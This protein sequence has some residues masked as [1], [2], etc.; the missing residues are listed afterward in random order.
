MFDPSSAPS[1][2]PTAGTPGRRAER[3]PVPRGLVW[4]T[5]GICVVALAGVGVIGWRRASSASTDT[6]QR[7][8]DMAHGTVVKTTVVST[9]SPARRLTL[10]GEARPFA[11]VTL[12]AK[13]SGYLK[14]IRVDRG[15]RVHKGDVLATI[16]SPETDRALS[17][18]RLEY[19]QR[20]VTADRVAHLLAKAFVSPQESDQAQAD[21]AVARERAAGFEEM[22]AY[23]TLRAPLDG[24][25]TARYAD[26][27]ALMQS[28]ATSQSSALPVLTV[29][30]T[31]RLRVFVYLDQEVAA[32][33]HPGTRAT[34]T[35]PDHPSVKISAA[36]TRL[37]GTLDAK[38]RKMVAE[39]DVDDRDGKVVP[40]SFI[41]V[42][43]E[44]PM[45]AL[46]EAP[47]EALL[48][49]GSSTYVGIID[50]TAHVHLTPVTVANNDGKLVT[51][52]SGVTAGQRVALSLGGTV[53][54]GAR[55]Q[56]AADSAHLK[57]S[58]P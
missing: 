22:K 11:E 40:G 27:G 17:G 24:T 47:A 4:G 38:T 19:E 53:A 1:D 30:Q 35:S 42:A 2:S 15:D 49:R 14:T 48:V 46:P 20:R 57:S 21:A 23:E 31:D 52:A 54:D 39:L 16:E 9:S 26:P 37:S 36:V 50:A 34:I 25:V 44:I 6:S 5:A 8:T 58:T 7:L 3:A 18:A 45:P 43:L 51:F 28:A 29:S 32:D 33:V 55:I 12:Y 13:V 10:L 41:Q 56:V